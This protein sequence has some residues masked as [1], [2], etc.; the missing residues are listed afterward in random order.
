MTHASPAD[1]P[2][3]CWRQNSST[4]FPQRYSLRQFPIHEGQAYVFLAK[5]NSVS[6]TLRD[7]PVFGPAIPKPGY[8]KSDA[9]SMPFN[10][11]KTK[12]VS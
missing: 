1:P 2:P 7:R 4:A 6:S 11:N 9:R 8:E 5:N 12:S 10:K 3:G